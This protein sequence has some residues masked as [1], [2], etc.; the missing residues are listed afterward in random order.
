MLAPTTLPRAGDIGLNPQ[1][2]VFARLL[3]AIAPLV[4]GLIPALQVSR[5]DLRESLTAGGRSVRTALRTRTRAALVVGQISLAILL[6]VGCTL[7][8][9]SFSRL[10][11]VDPGFDPRGAIVIGMQVPA[12]K[13][14]ERGRSRACR[15]AVARA[16]RVA[17]RSAGGRIDAEPAARKRLRGVA[18]F[19]GTAAD[20]DADRPSAN[21]YSVSGGYFSAMAV[22]VSRPG[23]RRS[24]SRRRPSRR[25]DQRDVRTALLSKRDPIGR[26]IAVSQGNDDWREIVGVVADTKQNGLSEQSPSQVYESYQQQPF[27]SIDFIVRTAAGDPAS[28]TSSVRAAVQSL[29][30][31]QP[32]GR[33]ITLQQVVDNSI[34]SQ[35]FSLALFGAFAAVA[36]LLAAI[37]LYGLV[38]YTVSQR[39]EEIGLRLAL[40]ARPSDVLRLIVR[41][42]LA[43]AAA[44]SRSVCRAAGA[45]RLMQSLLFETGTHDPATFVGVPLVLLAVIVFASV[46]PARRAS[47]VDPAITLRGGD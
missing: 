9:R 39:T 12:S 8:V 28:L 30:P 24:R 38:A 4:F 27:S 32:L 17:A 34:G 22:R 35:R 1:V 44:A 26:R 15:G 25:R 23:H 42:A 19:R 36:L 2:V 5:T 21:F 33:V 13:Y 7:L 37:G 14:P 46:I 41:Q 45:T 3:A 11:E 6:L 16:D 31:D 47:R 20:A 40:G 10:L 29:D 43:L 18:G